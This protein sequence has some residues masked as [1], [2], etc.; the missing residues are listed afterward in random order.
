MS[1]IDNQI[2]NKTGLACQI[3]DDTAPDILRRRLEQKT[4]RKTLLP[5]EKAKILQAIESLHN[6]AKKELSPE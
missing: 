4:E 1:F 2:I 5:D 3:W 6:Q